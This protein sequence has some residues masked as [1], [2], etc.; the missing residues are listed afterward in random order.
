MTVAVET[1]ASR[2]AQS[3]VRRQIPGDN[4]GQIVGRVVQAETIAVAQA[5]IHLE[6][7]DK[8][9]GTEAAALHPS[10]QGQGTTGADG[11]AEF[12]GISARQVLGGEGI[13]GDIPAFEIPRQQQLELQFMIMLLAG[14]SI[15]IGIVRSHV[16]AFNFNPV[17]VS[18]TGTTT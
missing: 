17:L 7:G 5:A 2:Q 3:P 18:A 4:R 8:I 14:E 10:L 11:V 15:R 9:L 1:E 12:P 16:V 6:P 13:F